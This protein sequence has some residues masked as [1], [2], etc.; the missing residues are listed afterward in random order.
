MSWFEYIV[1]KVHFSSEI[2]LFYNLILY[3]Y[4]LTT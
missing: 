1:F 3:R 4:L 2:Q